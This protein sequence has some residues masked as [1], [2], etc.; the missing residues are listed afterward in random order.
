M[1]ILTL[2]RIIK[3][4]SNEWT[5]STLEKLIEYFL[6]PLSL[7]ENILLQ[8][9]DPKSSKEMKKFDMHNTDE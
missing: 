9:Y 8:K 2:T 5:Y 6:E 7:W 3:L 1:K 4:F